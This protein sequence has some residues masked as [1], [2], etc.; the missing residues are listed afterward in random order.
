M[1]KKLYSKPQVMSMDDIGESIGRQCRK[2]GSAGGCRKGTGAG[3][4]CVKGTIAA[5]KRCRTGGIA[6]GG[7]CKNGSSPGS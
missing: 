4:N 2:G 7:R 6:S 5:G 1:E 3:N